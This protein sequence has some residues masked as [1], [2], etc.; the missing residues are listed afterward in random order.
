M[1]AAAVGLSAL[2]LSSATAFT[3]VKLAGAAYLIGLG[4]FT[5]LR[6]PEPER[7]EVARERRLRR[8]YAQ[9][10]VVNILNPKT[11]LFFLAF[12]PQFVDPDR[13]AVAAQLIALGLVFVVL[14]VASDCLWALA[15]GTASERLRGSRRFLAVRRYVSGTVFVGLG[16]LTAA[17]KRALASSAIRLDSD[18]DDLLRDP[19]RARGRA[20][21]QDGRVLQGQPERDRHRRPPRGRGSRA[22]ARSTAASGSRATAAA[23]ASRG[24]SRT[25][26]RLKL[27]WPP[28]WRSRHE[29]VQ[30]LHRRRV[31]RRRLG[32]DLRVHGA[33]ERRD[34]RQ[35]S[36]LGRRG[37]RPRRRGGQGCLRGVAP[38]ARAGA[39]HHPPPL[40]A[41]ARGGEAGADGADEP[42]DGQGARGGRRRRPGGDRHVGLHGRRG[43][44]PLRAHDALRA[45]RQVPDVGA[46][47]DRR[48]RRDH[49]VEL[50]DR[51]PGVE[52]GAGA[53]L[54]QHRRAQAGGGHAA[55]RGALHRPAVRG[56]PARRRR[57]PRARLR[58]GGGRPARAPPGRARDHVH[59]LARHR[60]ARDEGG[61]RQP[62][63]RPPRARR[64]ER[65]HRPRRRRSRPGRRGH[66]LVGVRHLRASAA[67]R[68]AAS[69][70]RRAFTTSC[71]SGLSRG[72]RRCGSGP[73][74]SRTPISAR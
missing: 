1:T 60:R 19:A 33:G 57:Q 69:S 66:R 71:R 40:R 47:A 21:R 7:V 36:A 72:P 55:A 2:V 6:R 22:R 32:R 41:P 67:P 42:R 51:D 3:V 56:R 52:A 5:L 17:A 8:I 29:A 13:G 30:E 24:R 4:L 46:H 53:R 39:R 54:R 16:A 9:G 15:A 59:R 10:V 11:A 26:R 63:A 74:G 48:R 68:R 58:R 25:R 20:L 38:G 14:A 37:R 18:Q 43:P 31:G 65:D 44:P 23:R 49:A 62:Q 12:L 70:S 50:P 61:R 45:P 28:S 27:D 73:V 64:Q 34:P 35:L